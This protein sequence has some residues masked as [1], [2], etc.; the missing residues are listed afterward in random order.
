MEGLISQ[1]QSGIYVN[2]SNGKIVRYV[3]EATAASKSRVNKNGVTVNEEIYDA[4]SGYLKD[5]KTRDREGFG[6]EW[7]IFLQNG[8]NTFIVSMNY[9]SAYASSF[10]KA[11][12]LADLTQKLTLTPWQKEDK[13][14]KKKS[15]IYIKD[16][17]HFDEH[18]KEISVPWLY[19]KD[20][21]NGLPQ[22]KQVKVKGVVTWDDSDQMEFFENYVQE[23]VLPK[24][25]AT[26]E[27]EE[28]VT[29]DEDLF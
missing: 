28:P 14:G 21:P 25:K 1:N 19:T 2:V 9:S 23:K 17:K 12:P 10:F 24:L 13:E 5:I 26:V 15:S 18:G 22:L 3:K 6:K 16:G 8:E 27:E 4:V 7:Q 29:Q 11:L 20:N